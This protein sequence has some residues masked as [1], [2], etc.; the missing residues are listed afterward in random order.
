MPDLT[1]LLQVDERADRVLVGHGWIGRMELI[2]VD[3]V[4][5]EALEA[6][7]QRGAQTLWI[8]LRGPL[9]W[10]RAAV[11]ALGGDHEA[12]GIRVQRLGNEVLADFRAV[13]VCR[14]D[15]GDSELDRSFEHGDGFVV[16]CGRA[17]DALACQPHRAEAES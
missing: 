9:V 10:A 1:C 11:A 12:L 7:V 13:R 15:E 14:V 4:E 16:V 3:P 5:P 6:S 8:A 2:D 17:P